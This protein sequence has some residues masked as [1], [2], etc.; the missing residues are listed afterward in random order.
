MHFVISTAGPALGGYLAK[1]VEQFPGLFGDSVF[2]AKYPYFL[3]CFVSSC[4]SLV[5]FVIGYFYLKESNPNVLAD[6]KWASEANERTALLASTNMTVDESATKRIMPK[7]GS[8]RLVNQTSIIII[9]SYS[10][11]YTHRVCHII[12]GQ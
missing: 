10:Y 9:I 1:P 12:H 3:P 11:V 5:G 7:S 8:M 6:R 2:L 4:G